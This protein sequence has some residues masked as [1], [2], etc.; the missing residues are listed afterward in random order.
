MDFTFL[1]NAVSSAPWWIWAHLGFLG[2]LGGAV[3]VYV[4]WDY[5]DWRRRTAGIRRELE[6]KGITARRAEI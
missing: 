5:I 6:R 1:L 3:A 2:I 4:V